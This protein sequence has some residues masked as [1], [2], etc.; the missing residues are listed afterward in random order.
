MGPQP[1]RGREGGRILIFAAYPLREGEV[2]RAALKHGGGG[3][4]KSR[5]RELWDYGIME[6]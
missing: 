5:S 6:L 3:G 1:P 4:T 2:W